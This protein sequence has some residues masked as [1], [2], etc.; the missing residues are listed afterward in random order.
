MKLRGCIR[1]TSLLL[2]VSVIFLAGCG[3]MKQGEYTQAGYDSIENNQF[4]QAMDSFDVA[5]ENGEDPLMIA[6]GRGIASYY[7][8][9][10]QAAVDYYHESMTYTGS[11]VRDIDY[12]L[13][14]YLAQA[15]EKL[16]EFNEAIATYTAILN[17]NDKDVM[18]YYHRGTDYL[19]VGEHDLAIEDFEKA[20]SLAPGNYDLRIEVAGRLSDNY[21]EEEGIKYLQNF[22]V[23]NEKKLSSFDKGRIYYYM[24][25]LENAKVYLEDARDDDDQNT[26]LFLGKTYEKLGD[27]NYAASVYDNFLKRHPESAI[28]YNQLGLSK[29]EAGDYEAA[30]NAFMSAKNIENN[31]I[32]QTLSYNEIVAT[33]YMGDFKKAKN[34]MASY[35]TSYPDDEAAKKENVFL[36]T[37]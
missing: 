20:L 18:A 28:I 30:L 17:L 24:G 12:D 2:A 37:R 8:M 15:Y 32:E 22:L 16:D 27:Y 23:D 4:S 1:K 25:D 29:L 31:G 6:R 9:D 21:Y 11:N 26:V 5:Q 3:R 13:N 35:L 14:F 36:S 7:L 33:E 19:K 34:L 10:Y